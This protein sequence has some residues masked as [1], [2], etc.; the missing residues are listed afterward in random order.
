MVSTRI[1]LAILICV[2]FPSGG[3][4]PE[5]REATGRSVDDLA[6]AVE[7]AS[8]FVVWESNRSG[9][10]RIWY[11]DLDG[12]GLRRLTPDEE[13]RDHFAPHLSPDGRYLAYLSQ[14]AGT[15]AYRASKGAS[16]VLRLYRIEDGSDTPLVEGARS[17]RED[18][19][20]VWLDARELLY[21]ASDGTTRRI[22]IETREQE[23]VQRE[24][25][26]HFGYLL[27]P[28]LRH[29]T[30][31]RT[32][33]ARYH[34]K[35]RR[36]LPAKVRRGCQPY[37]S[38][39]G[40][41][42]FWM[43]KPGGPIRRRDLRSSETADI[44][45]H[46]D[47]SLPAPFSYV[48]FPMVSAGQRLLAFGA[49]EGQH[50]HFRADYEIFVAPIDPNT[51]M[52]V[53]PPVR[54]SFDPGTDRFPDVFEAGAELGR[55]W[56]EAPLP[57]SLRPPDDEPWQ[58][59]FGDGTQTRS[60]RGNHVYEEVGTYRVVARRGDATLTGDVHVKPGGPPRLL[61]VEVGYDLTVVRIPFDEPVSLEEASFHFERLGEPALV[62]LHA[63]NR[64]VLVRAPSRLDESDHLVIDGVRDTALKPHRLERQRLLIE[65]QDWPSQRGP[66]L[67]AWSTGDPQAVNQDLAMGLRRIEDPVAHGRARL[68][69]HWRMDVAGGYFTIQGH[70]KLGKRIAQA[71]AFGLELTLEPRQ[72]EVEQPVVI[73]SMGLKLVHA[74]FLLIQEGRKLVLALRRDRAQLG[75][76]RFEVAELSEPGARHLIVTGKAGGFAAYLDGQQV[77]DEEF[78]GN[79][80]GLWREEFPLVVG[81]SPLGR[82]P[83]N[84]VVEGIAIYGHFVTPDEARQN[85]LAYAARRQKRV[86]VESARVLARRRALSSAPTSEAIIPYRDGLVVHEYEVLEVREGELAE[87]VIR[88]AHYAVQA[89][90]DREM[91]ASRNGEVVELRVEHFEENRQVEGI[92]L[93]DDLDLDLD[94]PLYLDVGS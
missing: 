78:L 77:V 35:A 8:G 72:V 2:L 4:E 46:G 1:A 31:G 19:A 64:T 44:V 22:D 83:W 57:V 21:I 91:A 71:G 68:D 53:G 29:A 41:F 86:P 9:R 69:H 73:A 13:G 36:V 14:R 30:S 12:S 90:A 56:G 60:Q 24:K 76:A 94:V 23:V 33:F 51:L 49:S 61:R 92:F 43:A 10:W 70:S 40:R 93:A 59:D 38:R 87:E 74:N 11:R 54:Y 81:A 79:S 7:R 50:D 55:H 20:V 15:N 37:F 32:S 85:A 25:Q 52:P 82:F 65:P 48:Y 6:A 75:A 45:L 39:D 84:G 67:L 88:V 58:W 5:T 34:Q 28:T 47:P 89:G 63:D 42:G 80:F 27:D 17:Y 3:C 18:R 26:D 66:A 16:P 62:R